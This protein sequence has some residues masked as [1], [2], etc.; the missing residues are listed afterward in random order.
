MMQ[1]LM[2]PQASGVALKLPTETRVRSANTIGTGA[3]AVGS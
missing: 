1:N 3:E 2:L